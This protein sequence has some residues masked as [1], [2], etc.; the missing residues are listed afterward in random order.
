[1]PVFVVDQDLAIMVVGKVDEGYGVRPL[2]KGRE[3][4]HDGRENERGEV[5]GDDGKRL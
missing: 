2:E 1:M 4:Q 3:R 5:H